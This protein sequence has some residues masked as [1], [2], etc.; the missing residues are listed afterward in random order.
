MKKLTVVILVAV[1]SLVFLLPSYA[2]ASRL[3]DRYE[4]AKALLSEKKYKEAE[5]AFSALGVYEDANKYAMYCAAVSAGEE[6]LYAL[7][8]TNLRSLGDFLDSSLLVTYY[9]GLSQEA[10]E[11]YEGA[12]ATFSAVT[13]Y[14]DISQRIAGY[15]EKINGRDYRRAEA[16][17]N[18]GRLEEALKGFTELGSWS[19][20]AERASAVQ[21][22]ITTRKYQASY[23]AAAEAEEKGRLEEALKGFTKLGTWEDSAER[24]SAVQEKIHARDYQ[25]AAEAEEKGQLEEA[26]DGFTK[27]GT[28]MDSE[29]RVYAVQE[30]IH[31]RDYAAA[32]E[33]ERQGDYTAAYKGFLSLG[34][35]LDSED[36]AA[37]VQNSANYAQA[38][39]DFQR[40]E[41]QSA[42]RLFAGLSDYEDSADKAWL[43]SEIP[44]TAQTEILGEGIGAYSF[45]NVWG[46]INLKDNLII[47]PRWDSLGSVDPAAGLMRAEKKDKFG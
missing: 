12:L 15:P 8:V 3:S 35:Y 26:L 30:K 22:K 47:S 24:A 44:D 2:E 42:Y 11:D 32:D 10:A 45:H 19:D 7:A 29:E 46:I 9:T 34:S 21:E 28:W 23:Q 16:L 18:A 13:L 5:E 17:E 41:L 20:S 43:L 27:L 40:G 36:R 38:M 4:E 1:F 25:A 6:G 39:E 31:A 14:R 33:A 37:A